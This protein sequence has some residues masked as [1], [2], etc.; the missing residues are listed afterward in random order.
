MKFLVLAFLL[1]LNI[2][3]VQ[4]EAETIKMF[5]KNEFGFEQPKY[6]ENYERIDWRKGLNIDALA[7]HKNF[8]FSS[9]EQG[10]VFNKIFLDLAEK[11]YI[12]ISIKYNP[13]EYASEITRFEQGKLGK[14]DINSRFGVYYDNFPYSKNEFIYPAF[15]ENK[16][17]V[18]TA[19]GT[20]FNLQGKDALKTYKGV[21][22]VTDYLPKYVLRDFEALG[23]QKVESFEKAFEI[24]LKGEADYLAGSYYPSMIEAYKIGVRNYLT[25]SKNPVWKAAMFFRGTPELMKDERLKY[26]QKYL[27]SPEY[28]KIKNDAFQ[29]LLDIYKRNTAGIV[30]PTYVNTDIIEDEVEIQE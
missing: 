16:I 26:L 3:T 1:I 11:T 9:N 17:Y 6:Y 5:G 4:A 27:K 8:P 20:K 18:I 15:F 28:K 21:Y 30:P 13:R 12:K 2:R 22:S 24:L 19:T 10:S 14:G 7:N 23:L 29:E 25:Y